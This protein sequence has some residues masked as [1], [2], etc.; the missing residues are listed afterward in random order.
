MIQ[1]KVLGIPAPQGSKNTFAVK[2]GGVYTGRT[3]TFEQSRGV[4]P[5]REA[6]RHECQQHDGRYQDGPVSVDILFWMPRPKSHYRTGR[7]SHLLKESAPRYHYGKPDADKLVRAV[8]D[9]ITQG[10]VIHDDGQAAVIHA[11]KHYA[12][13]VFPPGCVIVISEL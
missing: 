13:D 4:E 6:I 1:I 7:Y 9:A 10:G 12:G 3:V 11:E 2:K 5:W 8:L